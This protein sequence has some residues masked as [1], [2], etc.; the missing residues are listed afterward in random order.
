MSEAVKSPSFVFMLCVR[1]PRHR[2]QLSQA[3]V[4]TNL[5]RGT[6]CCQFVLHI[7]LFFANIVVWWLHRKDWTEC[8]GLVNFVFGF[9]ICLLALVLLMSARTYALYRDNQSAL[10]K[11]WQGV[12]LA[13]HLTVVI[14]AF[15]CVAG[16][17]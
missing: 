1:W 9:F 13:V 11:T 3:S 7:A 6:H 16:T 10:S 17:P 8:P 15:Y 14:T 5:M 4:D 12:E 2:Y